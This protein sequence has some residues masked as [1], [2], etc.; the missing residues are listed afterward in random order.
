MEESIVGIADLELNE[1]TRDL[2]ADL[3][4]IDEE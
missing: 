4:D 2:L 1:D 3:L